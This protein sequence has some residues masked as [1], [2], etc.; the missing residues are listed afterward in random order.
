MITY[1]CKNC[2]NE[3]TVEEKEEK[4]IRC[5]KCG[6]ADFTAWKFQERHKSDW[7]FQ[8]KRG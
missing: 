4:K 8:K 1:T 5:P 7:T 6:G 2:R 3:I